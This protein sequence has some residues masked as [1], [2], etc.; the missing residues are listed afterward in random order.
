[1][2]LN[3]IF[4]NIPEKISEELF[5]DIVVSQGVRIERILSQGHVSPA[6]GWYDQ[7]EN[8]WVIVLQGSGRLE[9]DNGQEQLLTKGDFINIPK[10]TKHRVVWT[11]PQQVTVWLA[12]FY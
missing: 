1:M 9:F 10:H 7:S 4:N 8:E 3:N 11:D 12:V 6:Q 2:E 5:E